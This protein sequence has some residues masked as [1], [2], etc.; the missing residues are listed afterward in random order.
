VTLLV[1]EN[2]S[3][4]STLV[5]AIAMAFGLAAEGGT[6]N[7]QLRRKR[8]HF[9]LQIASV[10]RVTVTSLIQGLVAL[11]VLLMFAGLLGGIGLVELVVW[12]VL[13]AAWLGWWLARRKATPRP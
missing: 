2:G 1:G 12:L 5:E 3:G 8:E 4:K 6:R 11:L 9:G 7:Q 13:V 10:V